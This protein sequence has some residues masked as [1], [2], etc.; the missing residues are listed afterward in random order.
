MQQI[1]IYY[2][3]T[4]N[5]SEKAENISKPGCSRIQNCN[6]CEQIDL[7]ISSVHCFPGLMPSFR[8]LLE[9]AIR[10]AHAKFKF[11]PKLFSKTLPLI[12]TK[13]LQ[14][15]NTLPFMLT[16][17]YAKHK[18]IFRNQSPD[19]LD[20]WRK[21]CRVIRYGIFG[22]VNL[23]ITES[24]R[25]QSMLGMHFVMLGI[26]Y[27]PTCEERKKTK[28]SLWCWQYQSWSNQHR[29]VSFSQW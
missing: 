10:G 2:P 21:D 4:P 22:S 14:L 8:L 18:F 1:I 7:W 3:C 9:F 19:W 24:D 5:H 15:K 11:S 17:F 28:R 20:L 27:W 23:K 6:Y 12:S 25:K 16:T 13:S 29:F 26:Y